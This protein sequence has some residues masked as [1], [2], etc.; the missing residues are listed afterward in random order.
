[1]HPLATRSAISFDEGFDDEIGIKVNDT[2]I[3]L[4][5]ESVG[6]DNPEGGST[7][8]IIWN[9]R[10]GQVTSVSIVM[11]L[12]RVVISHLRPMSISA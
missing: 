5:L 12:L 7:E 4:L 11:L 9:W 8:L 3:G 6:R 2:L 1:M 10:C